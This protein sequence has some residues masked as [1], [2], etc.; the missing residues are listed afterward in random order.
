MVI[1]PEL[2]AKEPFQRFVANQ[3][4]PGFWPKLGFMFNSR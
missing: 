4:Y 1:N 3:L 2:L